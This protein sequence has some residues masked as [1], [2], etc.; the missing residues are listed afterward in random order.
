MHT[1]IAD[2]SSLIL[3]SGSTPAPAASSGREVAMELTDTEARVRALFLSGLELDVDAD[4]DVIESGVLDSIAFVQLLVDLEREFGISVRMGSLDL[5]DFR[6][7]RSIAR[8]VE[9]AG[10]E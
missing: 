7:V 9:R 4:T 1:H 5:D 3:Q 8:H 6:S 10:V 2:A